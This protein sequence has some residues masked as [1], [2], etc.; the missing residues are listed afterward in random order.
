MYCQGVEGGGAGGWGGAGGTSRRQV[1]GKVP[2]CAGGGDDAAS[3]RKHVSAAVVCDP[4]HTQR[5][6]HNCQPIGR[7][8]RRAA[9]VAARPPLTWTL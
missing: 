1:D 3:R 9:A 8:W 4:M 2:R 6:E 7:C 5:H